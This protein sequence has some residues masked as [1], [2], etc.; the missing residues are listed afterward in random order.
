MSEHT[1]RGFRRTWIDH[2]SDVPASI[3]DVAALLHDIDGWPS[4]TPGLTEIRRNKKKPPAPGSK[5]TMMVKPASFHPPLPVPCMLTKLEPNYIEWGG[6]A[7]GSI[8]RHSFELTQVSP[9]LTR[10]RQL[11]FATNVLAVATLIAE[12]GIYKHDLRW[13]NALGAHFAKQ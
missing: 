13:Q 1:S 9:D 7:L 3:A 10:V 6:G 4:W 12:P 5:F 2:T 8:I 11:E